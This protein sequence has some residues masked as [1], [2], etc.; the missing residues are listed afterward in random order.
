MHMLLKN[1]AKAEFCMLLALLH[2]KQCS[3][4]APSCLKHLCARF[5]CSAHQKSVGCHSLLLAWLI[6]SFCHIRSFTLEMWKHCTLLMHSFQE[7][8]RPQKRE[9][10]RRIYNLCTGYT[11]HQTL[12][13]NNVRN[14]WI[15]Y[16]KY[17]QFPIH[18][19]NAFYV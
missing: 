13:E 15:K 16:K 19:Y 17:L 6:C 12:A 2:R 5:C 7:S 4:L 18:T 9:Q 8:V 11:Q 10:G 3:S 14:S 1:P